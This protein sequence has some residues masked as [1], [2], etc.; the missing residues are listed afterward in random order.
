LGLIR[1]NQVG[2]EANGAVPESDVDALF[3]ELEEGLTSFEEDGSPVISAIHRVRDGLPEGPE[4]ASLP[5]LVVD[6]RA[7]P[8]S[9][10]QAVVSSRFGIVRR[11]GA[12][13]GRSGNHTDDAWALV[14]PGRSRLRSAGRKHRVTDLAHTA[15]ALCGVPA[16]G[17]PL[18]EPTGA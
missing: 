7:T 3:D 5:D 14:A 12:G 4:S 1:V 2:R 16:G 9:A 11:L 8:A 17:E 18:L 13:T 10:T 15:L 6:W